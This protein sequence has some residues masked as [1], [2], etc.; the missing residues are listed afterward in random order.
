[1]E[2]NPSVWSAIFVIACANTCER[3]SADYRRQ[4]MV[5]LNDLQITAGAIRTTATAEV[6]TTVTGTVRHVTAKMKKQVCAFHGVPASRFNARKFEIVHLI[7]LELGG[8]NDLSN[9]WLQPYQPSPGAREK[10]ALENLPSSAGV[11]GEN[12]DKGRTTSDLSRLVQRLE[13]DGYFS[14]LKGLPAQF[15]EYFRVGMTRS[16]GEGQEQELQPGERTAGD[17]RRVPQF[18]ERPS[19]RGAPKLEALYARSIRALFPCIKHFQ[20]ASSFPSSSRVIRPR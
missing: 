1:M 7:P 9:L 3:Q 5:V 10:D 20:R 15:R 14:S 8:S 12:G 13:T 4:K 6:C 17:V 18:Q 16:L 11:F 19:V 2:W